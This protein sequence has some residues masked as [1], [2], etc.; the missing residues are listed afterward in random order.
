MAR[1]AGCAWRHASGKDAVRHVHH[2][3][4]HVCAVHQHHF[5]HIGARVLQGLDQVHLLLGE[6]QGIGA[7]GRLMGAAG[8][9]DDHHRRGAAQIRGHLGGIGDTGD[10]F[11]AGLVLE[12]FQDG[13]AAA[14]W[15]PWRSSR[16]SGRGLSSARVPATTSF[17]PARGEAFSYLRRV[18]DLAAASLATARCSSLPSTCAAFSSST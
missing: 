4:H 2:V 17:C 12:G 5:H 16:C 6:F 7:P 15:G 14:P 1:T 11:A 18:K 3:R 9:A 8:F 13:G 10:V